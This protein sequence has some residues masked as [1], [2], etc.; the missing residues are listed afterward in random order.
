MQP[1]GTP[2][3]TFKALQTETLV[4]AESCFAAARYHLDDIY[5]VF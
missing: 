3:R 5:V 2:A 4:F 1:E